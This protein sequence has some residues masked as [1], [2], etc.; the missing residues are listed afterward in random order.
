[1][2]DI[3]NEV[4][5]PLSKEKNIVKPFL[6]SSVIPVL[7]QNGFRFGIANPFHELGEVRKMIIEGLAANSTP[8]ANIANRDFG[9]WLFRKNF[10]QR[11]CDRFF[12]KFDMCLFC[13]EQS[14][15][16]RQF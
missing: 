6:P 5:L 8:L 1:M 14:K 12:V 15:K 13:M 10:F 4:F 16:K 2:V 7:L 11:L 3:H 9:N